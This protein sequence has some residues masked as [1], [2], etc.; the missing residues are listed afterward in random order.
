M[1]DLRAGRLIA[2]MNTKNGICDLQF[3][4]KDIKM[5]KL[6]A[7]TLEGKCVVYDL[8]TYHPQEGFACLNKS[9]SDATIWGVKVLPQNRDLFITMNGDGITQLYKY[10]YPNNRKLQDTDGNWKGVI[11]DIELLNDK[12][13]ANQP[14]VGFDFNTS[15]TGLAVQVALDQTVKILILTKLNLY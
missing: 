7:S 6:Y 10:N 4:R 11:G 13:T 15:K 12:K 2:E 14:V 9:I 1:F 3:D 8:R 5:N